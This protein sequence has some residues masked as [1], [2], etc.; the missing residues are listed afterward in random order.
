VIK[1]ERDSGE[2]E[3]R[4]PVPPGFDRN[5]IFIRKLDHGVLQIVIKRFSEQDE[6]KNEEW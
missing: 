4:I 1:C 2:F 3:R 5:E 6:E